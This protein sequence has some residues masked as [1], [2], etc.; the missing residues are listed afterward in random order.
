MVKELE[1]TDKVM[2]RMGFSDQVMPLVDAID[3]SKE[4]CSC[5]CYVIGYEDENGRECDSEGVYLDQKDP[6]QTHI[7]FE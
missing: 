6:A 4:I 5:D 2:V 1:R 7:F 3:N